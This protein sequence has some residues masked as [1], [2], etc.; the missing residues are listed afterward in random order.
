MTRHDRSRTALQWVVGVTALVPAVSALQAITQGVDGLPGTQPAVSA[1]VDGE[2]R[3][4]KVFQAAVAP[5]LW[6]HLDRVEDS[7]AVTATLSAVFAG[8][9]ARLLTW[10]R[11][12]R[13]HPASY[14]AIG[15]EVIA[16][17]GLLVWR[18][19]VASRRS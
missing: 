6:S 18:R 8:G 4:S 1:T 2:L 13:P 9:L 11:R 16:V 17:P 3:Y 19:R 10:R 15:L 12:G 5:V 7:P 14:V